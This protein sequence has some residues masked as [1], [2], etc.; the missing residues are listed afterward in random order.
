MD[1]SVVIVNYHSAAHALGAVASLLEQT[2]FVENDQPGKLEIVIVD[3]TPFDEEGKLLA[4]L[5]SQVKLLRN[6]TNL[7]Y[8]AAA[9]RGFQE[10]R[11]RY[12][13]VLNPDVRVLPGALNAMVKH[14][15]LYPEV[16]AVTP[17]FWWHE[18]RQFMMPPNDDPTL[19]FLAL[20]RLGPVIPGLGSLHGRWWLR[21]AVAYWR[22]CQ[23]LSIA[24]LCGACI[25]TRRS[26][27]EKVGGF[28]PGYFLYYE[29][30][31]WSR[32]FRAAGYRLA[33]VPDAEV[34]HYYNQTPK[35]D[36]HRS[37]SVSEA[38]FYARHYGRRGR[39]AL[40]I[41]ERLAALCARHRA[42]APPRGMI[43]LGQPEK[44]PLLRIDGCQAKGGFLI[45]VSHSW[46]FVP[47]TGAFLDGPE[48]EIPTSIW[49]R[50]QPGAYYAR[51]VELATL[52]PLRSWS[53]QKN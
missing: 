39:V 34:I 18:E 2:F 30:A 27:L 49:D 26:S 5:P 41:A 16:G 51:V 4:Q 35:S 12:L 32:R 6:E 20:T 13:C 33:Y 19:P 22:N 28:D 42:P 10:S 1:L 29:D 21:R 47:A 14:L 11:G 43:S 24:A 9:N 17:R 31:D 8:G 45:E 46:T 44:P 48:C 23:P 52:R 50:L 40:A 3:N 38:R 7:G 25:L 36:P 53:W 15:L 37:A